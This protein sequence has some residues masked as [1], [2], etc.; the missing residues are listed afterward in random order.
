MIVLLIVM[1]GT[2]DVVVVVVVYVVLSADNCSIVDVV[3][4]VLY[5]D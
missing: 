4:C 2:C 5:V 3:Q 1:V